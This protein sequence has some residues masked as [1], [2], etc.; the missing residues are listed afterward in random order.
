MAC[1]HSTLLPCGAVAFF[2]ILPP[3]ELC[4]ETTRIFPNPVLKHC[5][6][7]NLFSDW[8]RSLWYPYAFGLDCCIWYSGYSTDCSFGAVGE[9]QWHSTWM[10]RILLVTRDIRRQPW[11]LSVLHC[12]SLIWGPSG[13]GA[14]PSFVLS[15]SAPTWFYSSE[16]WHCFTFMRMTVR[17]MCPLERQKWLSLVAHLWPPQ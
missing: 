8:L 11:W 4:K 3:Y 9:H 5:T 12:S 2:K 10:V 15:L 17:S 13:L 14:K 7:Q 16:T 6:A 1:L